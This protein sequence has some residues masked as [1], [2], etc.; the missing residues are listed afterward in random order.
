M[1]EKTISIIVPIYRVEKYL[2]RCIDSILDQTFKDFELFLVDDGSP[3]KCGAICDEYAQRDSRIK[4]IHKENGGLSSARNVALDV[5]TGDYVMFVDSDDWVEP[6]F[7]MQALKMIDEQNVQIVAFGHRCVSTDYR[8]LYDRVTKSP[9][10]V[11]SSEAIRHLILRDDAI[12]NYPWN[13]IYKRSLFENIR[14]PLGLLHE[15]DAV[16]YQLIAKAKKIYVSDAILYNYLIR[17]DSISG[18]WFYPQAIV[19]RFVIYVKRLEDVKTI[20]HEN[21]EI[22]MIQ[23]ANEAV[24]GFVYLDKNGKYGSSLEEMRAFLSKNKYAILKSHVSFKQK[25]KI[26]MYYYART[27]LPLIKIVRKMKDLFGIN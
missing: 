4:V 16:T 25:S 8:I 3:D 21:T 2:R 24:E 19:D 6:D 17:K 10:L 20:C 15:D 14:Y 7:C 13:K 9:R 22:Q 26:V 1:K 5:A 11:E 23:T 27:F 12:Y 18:V